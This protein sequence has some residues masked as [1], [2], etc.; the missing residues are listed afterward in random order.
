MNYCEKYCKGDKSSTE[1]V[2]Y[3]LFI[4]CI[5]NVHP[6]INVNN[7]L[8][9]H[10]S[11]APTASSPH[12]SPWIKIIKIENQYLA[13]YLSVWEHELS[14]RTVQGCPLVVTLQTLTKTSRYFST[15]QFKLCNS[16]SN[17]KQR[18]GKLSAGLSVHSALDHYILTSVQ[19]CLLAVINHIT[20]MLPHSLKKYQ[21]LLRIRKLLSLLT[22]CKTI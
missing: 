10:F 20:L 4:Y 3:L 21:L 6:Q 5:R 12:F 13:V 22:V 2:F 1:K 15:F 16:E 9:P 19:G 7:T 18:F 8:F 14:K 11:N 17:S